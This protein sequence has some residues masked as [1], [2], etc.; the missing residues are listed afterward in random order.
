MV[1]SIVETYWNDRAKRLLKAELKRADLT[2]E[3]LAVKLNDLGF[4]ETKASISSKLARG[5]YPASFL[6]ATLKVIGRE[7]INIADYLS[8]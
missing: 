5:T 8:K 3:E 4:E 6:L 1:A 2:Y 7:T